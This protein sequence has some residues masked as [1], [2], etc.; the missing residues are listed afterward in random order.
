MKFQEFYEINIDE[1]VEL[2]VLPTHLCLLSEASFVGNPAVSGA[3]AEA[4]DL[5]NIAKQQQQARLPVQPQPPTPI[6]TAPAKTVV[7][8]LAPPTPQGIQRA[9]QAVVTPKIEE[10]KAITLINNTDKFGNGRGY[11]GLNNIKRG[12]TWY[13]RTEEHLDF[14]S[15]N[16]LADP[17]LQHKH[18]YG[19][20]IWNER[21]KTRP[22]R[23]VY[24]DC[25]DFQFRMYYPFVQK[26][27]AKWGVE[28]KYANNTTRTL[29]SPDGKII[30]IPFKHNQK[31]GG[32]RG[33]PSINISPNKLYVCKHLYHAIREYIVGLPQNKK[34]EG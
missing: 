4:D 10:L 29:I 5:A 20:V 30:Q 7:A 11:R 21:A 34:L 13:Y 8:P 32:T 3:E 15:F 17:T 2:Y 19:Y 12:K 14:L 16:F 24:C 9:Q 18:H 22:I 28:K 33:K 27:F 6:A 23:E 1:L 25:S 26:G 31:P